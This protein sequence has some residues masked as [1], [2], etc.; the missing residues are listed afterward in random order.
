MDFV[1]FV[2]NLFVATRSAI[3]VPPLGIL[4]SAP[5]GAPSETSETHHGPSISAIVLQPDKW[6]SYRD[7]LPIQA[8]EVLGTELAKAS[9]AGSY[10]CAM[11][12][13]TVVTRPRSQCAVVGDS[14]ECWLVE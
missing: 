14:V 12:E 5:S 11:F 7:A 13:E 2:A 6:H 1:I 8:Q 9:L 4:P 3:R 10:F